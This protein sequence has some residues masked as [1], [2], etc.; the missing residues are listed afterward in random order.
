MT[1]KTEILQ[2]ETVALVRPS[3]ARSS[4]LADYFCLI[5]PEVTFL[6]LIAT[7]LGSFMAA[8]SL[9][10]WV[11]FHCVLGTALLAG[12]TATLNHYAERSYDARMRRT[13]N[14]P[15][16]AG[17]LDPRSVRAFGVALSVVGGLYLAS[18]VNLL[19]SVIGLATLLSY[20]L[21]YTPLKRKTTWATF[22]GAFPGAAPA[23]MGWA[24]VRNTL[25]L[26]AWVLYAMLFLWQFP[27]FLSIAWIYREDYA[28]AGMLMLPRHDPK[29]NA[30]FRQIVG[31]SLALV[32]VS[33]LPSFLG[34]T[35]EIYLYCTLVLGLGFVYFGLWASLERSKLQA[36]VLLH[37]SVVY[38]PLVYAVMV[39][40]KVGR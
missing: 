11:L 17:R 33:L 15:L 18:F 7:A 6:V 19:T 8:D 21:V 26:E 28:R 39:I 35:G 4:K 40:D 34:M 25:D 32:P 24:A 38:L 23:L 31:Y 16:P 10:F 9:G 37:I 20:L 5:K 14:R 3:A 29:G 12:G 27:H 22:A 36:K 1:V 2:A 13:V 30:V